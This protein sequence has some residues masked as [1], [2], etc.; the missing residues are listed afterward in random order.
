MA[1]SGRWLGRPRGELHEHDPGS[2]LSLARAALALRRKLWKNEVFTTHDG[3][4][5]RVEGGSPLVCERNA[6][7]LVAVGMDEEPVQLHARTVLLG[8]TAP[9]ADDGWLESNTAAWVLQS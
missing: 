7:F 9:L 5:W 8:S 4:T 3:G 2:A 1:S 6:N